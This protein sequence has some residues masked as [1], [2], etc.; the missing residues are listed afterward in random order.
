[1][2]NVLPPCMRFICHPFDS[3]ATFFR[4]RSTG[5]PPEK[6]AEY[7]S[8][9]VDMATNGDV[10]VYESGKAAMDD[11]TG[12]NVCSSDSKKA[13]EADDRSFLLFPLILFRI[14]RLNSR[15]S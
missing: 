11:I 12:R 15:S 2:I 6:L 9:I 10:N 13:K 5:L 14:P 7:D 3:L 1:M 8:L 4:S